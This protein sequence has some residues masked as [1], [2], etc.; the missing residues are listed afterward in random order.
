MGSEMCIRDST[1]ENRD[2][3]ICA[4]DEMAIGVLQ[5]LRKENISVPKDI[6]VTGHGDSELSRVTAPTLTTVHY[7]YEESGKLAAE[8]LLELLDTGRTEKDEIKMGYY[9]IEN[10][11]S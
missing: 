2:A 11:S 1:Y 4:A 3:V 7:D 9:I 6:L 10:E 8:M 5:Y